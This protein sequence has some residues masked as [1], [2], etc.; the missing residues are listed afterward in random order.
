VPV[1][2]NVAVRRDSHTAKGTIA[3]CPRSRARRDA[4]KTYDAEMTEDQ[5]RGL[6]ND[7]DDH[8][9]GITEMLGIWARATRTDV[10]SYRVAAQNM[11][12]IDDDVEA[13]GMFL[14]P[15]R[16]WRHA[17]D[18]LWVAGFRLVTSAFQMEKWLKAHRAER[19]LTHD[20]SKALKTLR[21]T[22]EHLDE[23]HF[24]WGFAR[25]K[26]DHK[27]LP[28][29]IDKLPGGRLFLGWGRRY[30]EQVF[31]LISVE[32][33]DERARGLIWYD[34]SREDLEFEPSDIDYENMQYGYDDGIT[35]SDDE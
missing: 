29:S 18:G 4:G 13:G 12:S 20:E 16:E 9:R 25:K 32:K 7:S 26:D 8:L 23:A 5:W 17:Y 22:L 21:N 3:D 31:G 11:R 14:N 2:V 30:S 10:S 6:E 1:A 33:L 19:G 35:A 15:E 28:P 34:E 27:G 24:E